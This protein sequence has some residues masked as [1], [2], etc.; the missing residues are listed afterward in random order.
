M[1]GIALGLLAFWL[2]LPPLASR[3]ILW[4]IA[5]GVIAAAA[6]I[7]AV[8]RGE[9]RMGWGAIASAALGIGGG[10]LDQLGEHAGRI[11]RGREPEPS[12][13][14]EL[15]DAGKGGV[16][17]RPRGGIRWP[18]LGVEE[19]CGLI[20]QDQG[21]GAAAGGS[22]RRAEYLNVDAAREGQAVPGG[23]G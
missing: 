20:E 21:R 12:A 4:P 3:T 10:L 16:I 11:H 1:L 13:A 2:A 18:A 6:G 15:G 8:T 23:I 19:V 14:R 22:A 7:W 5:I 9:K 17:H